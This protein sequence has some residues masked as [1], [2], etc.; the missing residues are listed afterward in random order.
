MGWIYGAAFVVALG[1]SLGVTPLAARLAR[2]FGAMDEPGPRRVHTVPVPRWG[3]LGIYAGLVVSVLVLPA[4]PRFRMLLGFKAPLLQ[5]E[6]VVGLLE[7]DKQLMGLLVA[8]TLIVILGLVDDRRGVP[9]VVKLPWQIIGAYAAMLYGVRIGGLATPFSAYH[10]LP[11]L[12]SQVLTVLWLVGFMN[13]INLADG[14]DGLAAGIAAIAAGTFFIVAVL[15]GQTP[16][17]LFAKQLKLAAVLSAG[18]AGA[19]LGFLYHN[20]FPA[21]VFMGDTGSMFIGFMLG[22]ITVIGTLKTTALFALVI[23]VIVVALPVLDVS[24]AI[25]RRARQHRPI[26]SPDREHFHHRLLG[27]GWTQR[28]IVL[29][30]YN[31]TL[32]LGVAAIL[33]AIVK[34]P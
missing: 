34:A 7:M 16:V 21:K 25:V 28:E 13:T 23:P 9:S 15:L 20:F 6:R 12:A 27:L 14:L 2:R 32:L 29:L 30:V 1:V 4:F 24:F 26:M 22:A 3:G 11:I 8:G 18:L 31:L 19:S 17:V 33:L 5:G 10:A